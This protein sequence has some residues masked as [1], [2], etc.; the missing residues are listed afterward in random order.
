MANLLTVADT[1][2]ILKLHAQGWPQR[3]IARELDV[4]RVEKGSERFNK[5]F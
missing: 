5:S 3:R 2:A 1:Q 4:D